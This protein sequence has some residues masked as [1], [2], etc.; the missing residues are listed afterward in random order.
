MRRGVVFAACGTG[1][2]ARRHGFR[3]TETRVSMHAGT[4]FG[5]WGTGFGARGARVSMHAEHGFRCT[6]PL[7]KKLV[8]SFY[9]R[10][11]RRNKK[12]H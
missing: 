4:G 12:V 1:F 11:L 10:Y 6:P 3:C 8:N 7:L 5:A 9:I 2:D